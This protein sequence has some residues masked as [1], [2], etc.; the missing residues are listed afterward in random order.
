MLTKDTSNS[1][2]RFFK[3]K[4]CVEIVAL[5]VSAM[6]ATMRDVVA[7]RRTTLFSNYEPAERDPKGVP[8]RAMLPPEKVT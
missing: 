6:W 5:A 3:M 1:F 2:E 4:R 7:E 8:D